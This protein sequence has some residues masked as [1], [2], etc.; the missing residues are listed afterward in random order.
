MENLSKDIKYALRMLR[1]NPGFASV[2]IFI[3]ALGIGTMTSL[4][5]F[6]NGILLRPLPY[7]H[8][9]NLVR[10]YGIWENGNREGVSSPDFWDYRHL[11]TVFESTAAATKY[12]PYY[13]LTGFVHPEQ[14]VGRGVSS[15]YLYT[16]GVRRT[17]PIVSCA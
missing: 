12:T 10:A 13:S 11:N 9:E 6:L 8:S 14:L 1:R 3:L 5:S 16:L 17:P 4:F 2:A 7:E 15:G